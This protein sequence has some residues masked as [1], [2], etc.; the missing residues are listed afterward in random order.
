VLFY[1]KV[2]HMPNLGSN[3]GCV[4]AL[5]S[6][7]LTLGLAGAA[8]ADPVASLP[9]RAVALQCEGEQCSGGGPHPPTD[10]ALLRECERVVSAIGPV[11]RYESRGR[12]LSAHDLDQCNRRATRP[13]RD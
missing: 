11:S 10:A 2:T 8:Q 3:L 12:A 6:L 13:P 9:A 1:R 7:S 5:A 4:A